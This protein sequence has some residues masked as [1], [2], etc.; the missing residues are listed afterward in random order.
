MELRH[1]RHF[2]ALA[3]EGHFGRAA[4]RV[5]V[6]QQA[7]SNSIKNLEDEVGVPLVRRTT[8]R[9]QLTPAGEAFLMGARETL[10]EALQVDARVLVPLLAQGA[11]LMGKT[12]LHELAYGI[13]SI[14]SLGGQTRNPYDPT[15]NPGGSSGGCPGCRNC[16]CDAGC[17]SALS[18]LR[19]ANRPRPPRS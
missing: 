15:R 13:T 2:V 19:A 3:E 4:E 8:R 12:N 7:L 16:G 5:F 14:S 18:A 9:V 10:V 6:V 1:L 17:G 11:I